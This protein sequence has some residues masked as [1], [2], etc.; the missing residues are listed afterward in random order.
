[1]RRWI[2]YLVL[3]GMSA[4]C[5][6]TANVAQEKDTLMRLDREWSTSVKD[7]DKFLSYYAADASVYPPGM[8][9]VTGAANIREVYSKMSSAPGFSLEFAPTRAEVSASGD[10]GYTA[11]TYTGAMGGPPE[12]GKY[13]SVWKKQADGT[14]KVAADIFNS[15][16]PAA[17]AAH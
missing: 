4:G 3:V 10:V 17:G 13:V 8:P 16:L 6:S 12:T 11:G 2:G 9:V 5:G 1:M 14:W 7:I 15:D